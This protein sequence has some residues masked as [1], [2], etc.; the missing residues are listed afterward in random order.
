M[1]RVAG[2]LAMGDGEVI[3]CNHIMWAHRYVTCCISSLS[4]KL[5]AELAE[6]QFEKKV[7]KA[8]DFIKNAKQYMNDSVFAEFCK[9]GYMPR[10]KLTKLMKVPA[11]E[12][13]EVIDYLLI[14]KLAKEVEFKG[15]KI[16]AIPEN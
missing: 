12:L 16:L 10:G 5:G 4:S 11:K 7:I 3:K 6:S 13:N 8:R 15:S 14:S 2:L 9:L 1:I